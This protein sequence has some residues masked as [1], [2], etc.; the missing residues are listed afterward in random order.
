MIVDRLCQAAN[1][2]REYIQLHRDSTVGQLTIQP[3]L[4]DGKVIWKDE[5]SPFLRAITQ[6]HVLVIDEA[7]KSPVEVL[8]VLKGLVEDGEMILGDGRRVCR[9]GGDILI[10]DDFTLIVLANRPGYPFLG[11]SLLKTIGDVFSVRVIANPDLNSEIQ[12]LSSYGP[13]VSQKLIKRIAASFAELRSLSDHGEIY[14]PYSTREAVAVVKHLERFDDDV[15]SALH[16]VLD[17][18]SFDNDVYATIGKVFRKHGINVQDYAQWQEAILKQEQRDNLQIEY[19][20]GG[21]STSAE[22]TSSNPPELSSPKVG[23]WDENNDP[24]VGG[25]HW[26][27]GTGGSDTAG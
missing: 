20:K 23:K 16:N 14:Y 15:V 11:N 8:A 7:D 19:L 26:A 24:H 21:N 18:D 5:N 27:G 10:H 1:F 2:E 22:G 6:G 4:I 12:L 3:T 9:D 17:F 25:N 13:N